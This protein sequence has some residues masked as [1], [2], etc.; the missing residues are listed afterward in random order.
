MLRIALPIAEIKSK[1]Y[2]AV[3]SDM[4]AEPA[5]VDGSARCEDFDGLL[6]PGG[7][8]LNPL[9]YGQ[10]MNG[11]QPPD[12]ELDAL[13]FGLLDDFVKAKKPVFGICR[14]LQLINVFF[15][16]TLIQNLPNA[17]V[18]SLP[19]DET[20]FHSVAAQ[21]GSY[22]YALYGKTFTVNTFHHQ[23]IDRPG[24]GILVC[25]RAFDG[26]VE[27]ICHDTLPVWAV[28]FHPERMRK[29]F[30]PEDLAP[31]D[32]LIRMFLEACKR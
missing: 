5:V 29:G 16:G 18:H 8:D 11:S 15:G 7:G 22:L 19:M 9:R 20:N 14:G 23:A 21:E 28:Q 12:D 25:A 26:T 13:Q 3:L 4:G 17:N 30:L 1:S 6:L 24:R 31:G 32:K 27:G 2:C 10:E